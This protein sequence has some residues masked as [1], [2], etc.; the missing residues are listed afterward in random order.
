M[1]LI[2]K[3]PKNFLVFLESATAWDKLPGVLL[4]GDLTLYTIHGTELPTT[5]LRQLKQGNIVCPREMVV[6]APFF[7]F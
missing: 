3:V 7:E 5:Q 6:L 2:L 1:E 4:K